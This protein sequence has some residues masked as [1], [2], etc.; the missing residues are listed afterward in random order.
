MAGGGVPEAMLIGAA[1]GAGTGGV[2]A[3]A[4][5]QD[6][7]QGALLGAAMGAA[8]GGIGSWAGGAAAGAEGAAASQ[9][10]TSSINSA[11]ASDA[12]KAAA[13]QGVQSSIPSISSTTSLLGP[14]GSAVPGI[15]STV[16]NIAG[17]GS[18]A[19]SGAAGGAGGST[20]S[21]GAQGIGQG[22]APALT[23]AQAYGAGVGGGLM[24]LI[25]NAQNQGEQFAPEAD[26]YSGS[27]SYFK[28]NPQTFR[29]SVAPG[30]ADGGLT[31][32]DVGAG[33]AAMRGAVDPVYMMATGGI[34]SLGHY[35]DGGRM[36]KG[37]GDGM[38]DDIPGVI[39]GK[40][41]ARLAD[42]EFVVPA[43]VVS[44]LGNGS[45]DAG[46]KK[47]Y[48]MM[49]NVRKARTGSKK[50][51][52][53][54]KADKY[55]PGMKAGGIASFADGGS[56]DEE[57]PTWFQNWQASQENQPRPGTGNVSS[58]FQSTGYD[59]NYYNLDYWQSQLPA[60][61]AAYEAAQ[62]PVEYGKMVGKDFDTLDLAP[63][64]QVKWGAGDKWMYQTVGPDGKITL[65]PTTFGGD[66]AF[67]TV[68]QAYI[69]A[70]DQAAIDA[71]KAKLDPIQANVSRLESSG[72]KYDPYT[73]TGRPSSSE[74]QFYGNIYRPEYTDYSQ[75][76]YDLGA[77]AGRWS[78]LTGQGNA[79]SLEE[80]VAR[81]TPRPEFN[82]Q[83]YL[84]Q[85][86]GQIRAADPNSQ[87]ASYTPQQLKEYMGGA[88]Q[89]MTPQQHYEMYGAA[90]GLNPF[91][92]NELAQ[93]KAALYSASQPRQE[94]QPQA[95]Q[96]VAQQA[97][98]QG[99]PKETEKKRRGGIASLV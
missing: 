34:S 43:D 91:M 9:V 39:A 59:P 32:L 73:T 16:G 97:P 95:Q 92:S 42:G 88:G 28:Y 96:Q 22:F 58:N 36:L 7:L 86:L 35:S 79:P 87:F 46:A 45:T 83:G 57:M 4:K 27:L 82:E 64:T 44:H 51:G 52:R 89:N 25:G 29:P 17:T 13:L 69:T 5:D 62:Q 63:G 61:Q 48:S 38:S 76:G 49:D 55:V 72:I 56:T 6:P 85:K 14:G 10:P 94:A 53:Q 21:W 65:D 98:A 54:I 33:Q 67:G 18:G 60:A 75:P 23:N 66:P 11:L 20:A 31:D 80:Q 90:E 24:G 8:G 71:A 50:Q 77:G 47:L 68:K 99:A 2:M 1:V 70:P 15:G 78:N 37:P 40:Q 41:P 26:P 3:A 81:Y 84:L 74:P 12:T 30:Y 93:Y 19:A